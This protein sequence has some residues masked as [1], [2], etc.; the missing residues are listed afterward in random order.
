MLQPLLT[1]AI[2]TYNRPSYLD[3]NLKQLFHNWKQLEV[4]NELE[5]LISNNHSTDNTDTIIKN[6][7]VFGKPITEM[8][9][10]VL[11]TEIEST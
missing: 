3:I 2:P 7:I 9:P 8:E 4:K 5:I 11:P 10:D 6:N 1:I